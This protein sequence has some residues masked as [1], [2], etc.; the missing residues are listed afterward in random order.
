[1]EVLVLESDPHDA[2]DA[3]RALVAAGHTVRRCHEPGAEPFPCAA[4]AGSPC[5]ALEL[6]VDVA[7]T[8]RSRS[9]DRP[10]LLEDG[11]ACALR[12]HIP[13]VVAG[14]VDGPSP[15]SDW[16]ATVVRRDEVV[17]ACERAATAPLRR[18]TS[19]ASAEFA[20]ALRT[21]GFDASDSH[22]EVF[23][24]HGRLR[25]VLDPGVVLDRR[26]ADLAVRRVMAAV[27]ELDP[28]AGGIDVS[29]PGTEDPL[30]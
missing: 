21:G 12:S 11:V 20:R 14:E 30:T 10:T 6:G 4:L 24:R 8:V 26:A 1:M 9:V 7:V 16:A 25:A 22:A 17:E 13:V 27:R 29:L 2:D 18:H 15:Y 28:T 3:V 5:P 19:V 23:R